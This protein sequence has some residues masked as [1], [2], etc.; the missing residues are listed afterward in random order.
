MKNGIKY[1]FAFSLGAAAGAV[2]SWR[3]LKVK[4]E[5]IAREEIASV[6]EV[7]SR[8]KNK[9]TKTED[10]EKN[11]IE[12]TPTKKIGTD[13]DIKEYAALL[14]KEGYT[15]YSDIAE[16][17]N[18]KP[19]TSVTPYVIT[20][21]DFGEEEE[22]DTVS[23]TYYADGVLVDDYDEIVENADEV[24]GKDSLTRFGEYE[25]DTVYV[26]NDAL[27][28]DYE[29]MRDVRKYEDVVNS[30]KAPRTEG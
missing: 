20:P 12:E 10:G 3:I 29:I 21:E 27:K 15:K 1:F 26:R 17:K 23:Y 4:Y 5:Q 19:A 25:D 11:D 8:R 18:S 30:Y 22:Y 16:E 24:V 13:A 28:L 7:F 14:A 6:K 9:N 2:V